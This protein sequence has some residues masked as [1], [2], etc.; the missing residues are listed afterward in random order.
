MTY[1]YIHLYLLHII[2]HLF[3]TTSAIICAKLKKVLYSG[4]DML[5]LESK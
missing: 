5:V 1:M 4:T 2:I 3:N